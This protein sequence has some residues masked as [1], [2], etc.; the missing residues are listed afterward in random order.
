MS[1]SESERERDR[2]TDRDRDRDTET[3]RA[4][5]TERAERGKMERENIYNYTV[6]NNLD[7]VLS[8]VC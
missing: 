4:E 7:N 8:G 5:R 2:Q 6:L 3:G 1:E